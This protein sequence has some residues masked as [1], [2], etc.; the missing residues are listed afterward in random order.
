MEVLVSAGASICREDG[1][2]YFPLL[3]VD[4]VNWLLDH[5]ADPNQKSKAESESLLYNETPLT[6]L[7]DVMYDKDPQSAELV[8]LLLERGADPNLRARTGLTPLEVAI[9][10]KRH[11]T[12]RVLLENGARSPV[13]SRNME[14]T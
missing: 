8:K 12:V 4:T 6:A 9:H 13:G 7:C 14:S 5:D 3:A 2:G 1:S 11:D 10:W